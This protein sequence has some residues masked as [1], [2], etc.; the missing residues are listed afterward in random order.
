MRWKYICACSLLERA[1]AFALRGKAG[2]CPSYRSTLPRGRR[3]KS[4]G[5][6]ILKRVLEMIPV[7]I[8]VTVLMF[9]LSSLSAG[10]PARVLAEQAYNHPTIEQINQIRHEYGLDRPVAEQYLSWLKN[11]LHGD[12][13]TSLS[14]NRPALQELA[15]HFPVTLKLAL[16]AIALLLIICI[17]L[18]IL[19]AVYEG[20]ILD[21][22]VETL[23]FISASLP[24]FWI[25]LMLLY[26][27]GVKLKVIPVIG[28][29]TGGVPI[30]AA[31]TMNI[32][33]FGI[34]IRLIRTNLRDV[35]K[36]DY[37][38]AC[39]A[40]GISPAKIILKH[41]MKNAV[42]PAMTRSVSMIIGFFAGSAVIENIFSIRG[43][44]FLALEA[45]I[46]KDMPVLQCFILVL[47]VFVVAA[48]LLVDILY[49][50]IDRRIQ[51]K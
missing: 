18:G 1:G 45:V 12:F 48:N 42:I 10:D 11:V 26:L 17:P 15:R 13:G 44:G 31:F 5:K 29:T 39:R 3:R 24:G 20:S 32:G 23:C 46:T 19:S 4:V 40:K 14:T 21:R 35:L 50:L 36:Q 34:L 49:S 51:L 8:A 43:I 33:N 22:I 41:G 28:G 38:R 30:V 2:T 9:V 47:S 25:G 7:L 37:I 6:Y 27:L 16:T